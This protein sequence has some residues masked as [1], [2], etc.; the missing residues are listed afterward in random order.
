MNL[1]L[2]IALFAICAA[3]LFATAQEEIETPRVERVM[4]KISLLS[5]ALGCEFGLAKEITVYAQASLG[6]GLYFNAS[7]NNGSGSYSVVYPKT[8]M[9]IRKYYSLK[10]RQRRGKNWRGN[11]GMFFGAS[12][13]YNFDA[14][15]ERAEGN[16]I[17][18]KPYQPSFSVGPI[19]GIQLTGVNNGNIN[20]SFSIGPALVFLRD[21]DVN[22]NIFGA[23][24]FNLGFVLGNYKS[25]DSKRN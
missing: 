14:F 10:S 18:T 6:F 11:S 22:L 2:K 13:S 5:P 21:G 20:F 7:T 16:V 4:P 8:E 1:I 24:S 12:A 23:G 19:W 25:K 15:S 17:I 9:E 3:P